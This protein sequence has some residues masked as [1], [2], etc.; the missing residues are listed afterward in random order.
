MVP[1]DENGQVTAFVEK[2][3]RDE[4][5]TNLINAGTYVLEPS[6]LERVPPGRRVSIERETFPAMVRDRS[7]YALADES[8]W[9]DT[10]TPADYLQAHFDLVE[11]RRGEPPAPGARRIDGDLWAVGSPDIE[12]RTVRRLLRGR[13]GDRGRRCHGGALGAGPGGGGRELVPR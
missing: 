13:R 3:P 4:A 12:G 11:G 2:P 8:Y 9:L 6:F 7:L 10:G 5:P 1:T